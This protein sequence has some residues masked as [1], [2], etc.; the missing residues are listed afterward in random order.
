MSNFMST[1]WDSHIYT[2]EDHDYT[3]SH[4]KRNLVYVHCQKW[5]RTKLMAGIPGEDAPEDALEGGAE[6]SGVVVAVCTVVPSRRVLRSRRGFRADRA[7]SDC[8]L[9]K[10]WLLWLLEGS[11][12]RPLETSGGAAETRDI[13]ELA[14]VFDESC[15]AASDATLVRNNDIRSE[16][17]SDLED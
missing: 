8:C 1:T 13:V 11:S 2:L 14:A 6:V 16:K 3:R 7:D 15:L 5:N 12:F 9:N 4:S 17:A 10:G